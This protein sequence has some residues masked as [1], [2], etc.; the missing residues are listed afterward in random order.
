MN[1]QLVIVLVMTK[2]AVLC[3]RCTYCRTYY[4]YVEMAGLKRNH[5][6]KTGHHKI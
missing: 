1:P 2:A 3:M 5:L 4:N 6:L